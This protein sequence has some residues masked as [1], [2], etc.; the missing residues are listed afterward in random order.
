MVL[1][2]VTT[3]RARARNWPGY[4]QQEIHR[5]LSIM[6][7]VFVAIHVVTSI[8]DT[9]VHIGWFSVVVP[10]ASPYSRFWVG[11]GTIALDL[12]MAVFVSSLVRVR[13]KPSSWRAI[14]WVAYGSWPVAVFHT[15]GLG[16]DSSERWF[17]ALGALSVAL[18]GIA[19]IWR[20]A[21]SS[22][23]R[24]S[25]GPASA[26]AIPLVRHVANVS[27]RRGGDDE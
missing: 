9:Y 17:M 13:L 10:F 11:L 23:A 27:V 5:R 21:T 7:V 8:L 2:L 3:T 19:F 22:S 26:E 4:A 12:M 15:F 24:A 16:T 6:A 1:G 18:V 25:T 14:H 20:I